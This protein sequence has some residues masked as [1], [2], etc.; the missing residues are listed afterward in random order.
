MSIP[1]SHAPYFLF[2]CHRTSTLRYTNDMQHT[3]TH[4][5]THTLRSSH[6]R[7]SL[8]KSVL[9]NFGKFTEKHLCQSPFFNKV[10]VLR[11]AILLKK[12]TLAQVFSCKFFE[13]FKNTFLYRTPL[14][15]VSVHYFLPGKE[16]FRKVTK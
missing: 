3:H 7:C 13:I 10:A 4:T 8:K 9:R 1:I 14:V 16:S 5:H 6:R 15:A 2:P 12:E 11:H